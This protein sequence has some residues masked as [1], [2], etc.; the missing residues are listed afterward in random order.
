MGTSVT[1]VNSSPIAVSEEQVQRWMAAVLAARGVVGAVGVAFVGLQEMVDLNRRYRG[2]NEPTDV[3]SF[4][5]CQDD[6]DWVE[7]ELDG[8]PI[9]LGDI[10]IAPEVAREN[11]LADKETLSDE[12]RVLITHGVLH[13]LGLDHETDGGEMLEAQAEIVASLRRKIPGDLV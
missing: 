11:A 10:V 7:A 9:Y 5:E 12:L 13:L 1:V 3:L 2:L 6:E 4:R 8:E